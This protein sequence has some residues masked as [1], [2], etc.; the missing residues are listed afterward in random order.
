MATKFKKGEI[1]QVNKV[2]P[3][4]PVLALHMNADG[5][6]FY[7]IEWTDAEGVTQQRWFAEDE[8]V[9]GA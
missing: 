9:A 7:E 3:K 2:I 6:F 8:L 4:G 5:E 1:V